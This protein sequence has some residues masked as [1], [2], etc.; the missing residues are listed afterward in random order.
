MSEEKKKI[1]PSTASEPQEEFIDPVNRPS[2]PEKD[3]DSGES[4]AGAD[5]GE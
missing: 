3:A 5:A 1:S 2:V 4:D